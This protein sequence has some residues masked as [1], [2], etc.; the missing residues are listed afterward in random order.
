MLRTLS[1]FFMKVINSNPTTCTSRKN[2]CRVGLW[3]LP[4]RV[5]VAKFPIYPKQ[6]KEAHPK[7]RQARQPDKE[8]LNACK[9]TPPSQQEAV[10]LRDRNER[11]HLIRGNQPKFYS[12]VDLV[13][14]G[15][16]D[17]LLLECVSARV[18]QSRQIVSI[19]QG[20]RGTDSNR[21]CVPWLTPS[22][23]IALWPGAPSSVCFLRPRLDS[24]V[25]EV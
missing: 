25:T 22:S 1:G 11:R 13:E 6:T 14:I 5:G 17:V 24:N 9:I 8:K 4:P 7:L 15:I 19:N 21:I 2:R 20:A 23:T 3:I 18:E 12:H 16:H 10:Q